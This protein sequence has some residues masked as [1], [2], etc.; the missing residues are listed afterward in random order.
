M[1]H[2]RSRPDRS[3]SR[4]RAVWWGTTAALLIGAAVFAYYGLYANAQDCPSVAAA[5]IAWCR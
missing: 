4:F 2:W 5:G 1:T 3:L